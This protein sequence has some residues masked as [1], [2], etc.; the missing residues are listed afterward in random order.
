M[1]HVVKFVFAQHAVVDEDAG[2]AVADGA[3]QEYGGHGGVYA[4]A[5]SE[6]HAVVADLL[7]ERGYGGVDKRVGAP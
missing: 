4:A 7:F 5:E 2:E 1:H 6:D 3:V